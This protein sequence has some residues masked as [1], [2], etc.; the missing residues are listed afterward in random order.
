MTQIAD[1]VKKCNNDTLYIVVDIE[2][3]LREHYMF[4]LYNLQTCSCDSWF[5]PFDQALNAS[6]WQTLA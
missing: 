5:E 4:Q 6:Y 3:D 1:I 2:H